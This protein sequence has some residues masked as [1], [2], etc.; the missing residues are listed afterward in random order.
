MNARMLGRTALSRGGEMLLL[1][2][3]FADAEYAPI[4]VDISA[5][6]RVVVGLS[7]ARDINRNVPTRWRC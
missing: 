1:P 3:L 7:R 5:D 4:P 2:Q 6:G